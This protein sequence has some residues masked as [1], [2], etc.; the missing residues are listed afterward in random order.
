MCPFCTRQCFFA[1]KPT[2]TFV[3][4]KVMIRTCRP[5]FLNSCLY[6]PCHWPKNCGFPTIC[7][8]GWSD[9]HQ[10]TPRQKKNRPFFSKSGR[11]AHYDWLMIGCGEE[12]HC[13][14][15][16]LTHCEVFAV[17]GGWIE[18]KPINWSRSKRRNPMFAPETSDNGCKSYDFA[19]P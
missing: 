4:L 12:F 11:T 3:V 7:Q 19:T 15:Q 8:L 5:R 17:L 16:A 9:G 6:N 1:Q 13:H 2:E 10:K 14:D 18:K